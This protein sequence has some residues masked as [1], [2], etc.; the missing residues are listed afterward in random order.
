M[1]GF[2]D[3]DYGDVDVF[4]G[5]H[6]RIKLMKQVHQREDG[7]QLVITMTED[8]SLNVSSHNKFTIRNQYIFLLKAYEY[9]SI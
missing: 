3:L 8:G 7:Y 4:E 2:F 9:A 1:F 5:L 6:E